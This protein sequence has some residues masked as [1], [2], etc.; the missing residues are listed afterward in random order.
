MSGAAGTRGR[1]IRCPAAF[2]WMPGCCCKPA[3]TCMLLHLCAAQIPLLSR[4]LVPQSAKAGVCDTDSGRCS[5]PIV[6]G[7][8]ALQLASTA[9]VTPPQP[10]PVSVSELD[11]GRRGLAGAGPVHNADRAHAGLQQGG[12]ACFHPVG[13]HCILCCKSV[14]SQLV[15]AHHQ[16]PA[17]PPSHACK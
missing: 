10:A 6:H 14:V 12:A 11:W 8:S 4:C 15:V 17:Q 16:S 5:S 1:L 2:G 7:H 13:L 3:V 9:Q